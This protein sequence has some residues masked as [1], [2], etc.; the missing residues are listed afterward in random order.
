MAILLIAR[1]KYGG[2]KRLRKSHFFGIVILNRSFRRTYMIDL[3]KNLASVNRRTKGSVIRELLKFTNN[4]EIISF[5]GGLPDPKAF[6][7]E[8]LAEIAC[9]VLHK[10]AKAA[11]Q[12]GPTDGLPELK[13]A[14]INMLKED[15]GITIKPE[16]ILVTTASQQ[17]LDI[18]GKSFIDLADPVL[19]ENPS[20]IGALQ[21]FKSYGANMVGI[22][23]DDQGAEPESLIKKLEYLKNEEEHYKFLY[24]IP[25]FQNPMGITLSQERREKIV[26]IA[27]RYN[28]AIIE[29]SPYRHIRFEGKAPDMLYKLDKHDNVISLFT[30]S[31]TLAP[32]FRLGFIVAH[33]KIIKKMN[34]LKQSLDLCSPSLCQLITAEY[35]NRGLLPKHIEKVAK[36]YKEKR[37]VM[38]AALKEY[39]PEGVT[40]TE[41]EGGLFLWVRLPGNMSADDMFMSAI[42]QK[43]AY[44]IGSAFHPQPDTGKN[45]M[46]LNFSYPT[47]EEIRTGIKRLAET[48]K[49]NMK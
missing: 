15:E 19:V 1:G 28:I 36:N 43:V 14:I 11:L 6:P 2:F 13:H 33:E 34:I 41:P 8:E 39:M 25:D 38:L 48:I 24:L 16:N 9:D 21:V 37:D 18:V 4:P 47:H 30:F 7:S 17:A 31:K 23:T 22:D 35:L 12:Y 20:Y 45:T 46:R 49:K 44:V 27:A 40:W 29:D 3:T 42:E 10:N 5:A 26:E 32:G